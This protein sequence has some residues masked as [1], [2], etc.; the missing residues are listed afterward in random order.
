MFYGEHEHA[1]DRKGRIIVP[2]G[3]RA[4]FKEYTVEKLFVTRGL[5]TCLFMFTEEEWRELHRLKAEK[6]DEQTS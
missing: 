3:F 2:S 6:L 4:T 5:D 1:I